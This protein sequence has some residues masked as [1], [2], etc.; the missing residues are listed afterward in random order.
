MEQ[1]DRRAFMQK[2]GIAGVA[3]AGLWAAPSVL[4]ASTAFADGS[5]VNCT[6]LTWGTTPLF[7]NVSGG[8]ALSNAATAPL[9]NNN[10]VMYARIPAQGTSPAII[11][12]VTVVPTNPNPGAGSGNNGGVN[13]TVPYP[14]SNPGGLDGYMQYYAL[15]MNNGARNLGY[16]VTFAFFTSTGGATLGAAKSVYNLKFT[17][18]DI[19]LDS[20]TNNKYK[21]SVVL[22]TAPNSVSLGTHVTGSGTPLSPWTGSSAANGGVIDQTGNAA[23]TY[24][25]PIA[26]TSV[27][28]HSDNVTANQNQIQ[29]V[30][31]SNLT[32]CY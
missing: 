12:R 26:A 11:V 9:V 28:Y 5:L 10:R 17:L 25:G 18:Y 1:V 19:D 29:Y 16:T 2:A 3:T 21:D 31:I 6:G 22:S 30:G 24:T 15:N 14:G 27:T 32:W 13:A 4:G 23:V 7:A 20:T 8:V